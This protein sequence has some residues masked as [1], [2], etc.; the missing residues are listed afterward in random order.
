M[1]SQLKPSIPAS[2]NVNDIFTGSTC[3]I[4]EKEKANMNK[5]ME[6]KNFLTFNRYRGS[7][8]G[9]MKSDFHR[10]SDGIKPSIS[11]FKTKMGMLIGGFTSAYWTS[12]ARGDTTDSKAFLFNLSTDKKFIVRNTTSAI[13]CAGNYGPYFGSSS[14]LSAFSEPF[15]GEN[16][17]WSYVNRSGYRIPVDSDGMTNMLTN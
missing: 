16:N 8:D 15:N 14:E 1:Q 5:M 17:C 6:N 10:K 13:Y 7:R 9:W 12:A 2:V 11:L 3:N 4:T